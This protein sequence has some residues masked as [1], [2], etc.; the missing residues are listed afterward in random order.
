MNDASAAVIGE[1]IR[2]AL[3]RKKWTAENLAFCLKK[4]DA[5]VAKYIT[6]EKAPDGK[7]LLEIGRL[8]ELSPESLCGL[9][10]EA[11]AR[12]VWVRQLLSQMASCCY[13]AQSYG[14]TWTH[15]ATLKSLMEALVRA[16]ESETARAAGSEEAKR[17]R[18][19]SAPQGVLFEEALP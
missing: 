15:V 6:G 14:L 7:T 10:V 2:E 5:Q 1:N 16:V 9:Q 13:G 12:S 19:A 17:E 4:S 18:K 3:K 8:L 11:C